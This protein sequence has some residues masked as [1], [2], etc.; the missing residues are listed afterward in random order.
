MRDPDRAGID[1]WARRLPEL[2]DLNLLAVMLA[3]DETFRLLSTY[4]AGRG[5]SS[6][7]A[8]GWTGPSRDD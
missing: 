3:S 6:P 4:A 1:F 5:P 8:A 7:Y 2:G